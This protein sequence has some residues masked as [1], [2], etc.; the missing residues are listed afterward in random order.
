MTDRTL[1]IRGARVVDGTGNPWFYGDVVMAGE[2]I[3]A[4]LPA[5]QADAASVAGAAS[6]AGAASVTDA[7]AV[8][9]EASMAEAA[10]SVEVVEA[11]GLVVCPGFIDLQSH[12]IRPLMRDPRCLSKITQ[13]VTTE[14]M[15]EAWTPAPAGGRREEILDSDEPEMQ[16]WVEAARGWTRFGDW[17]EAMVARGVSPNVGSFLG[18]GTLREY[19]RG[20]DMG[21]ST[22]EE[23]ATMHRVVAEAM[24]DGAF[25]VSYALIYPPD[26]FTSTDELVAVCRE[27][28][29]YGGV[30]ITHIRDEAEHLLPALDEAIAIGRQ[31]DLPVEIY[32]LKA[33]GRANWPLMPAAIERIERAREQGIDVTAD[34]YPYAASGTGLSSVLPPWVSAGGRFYENLRDPEMRARIREEVLHPS[35]G[36]EPMGTRDGPEAVMPVGFKRAANRG[37]AGRRLS[38]IAEERGQNWVD[39]AIDLLLDEEQRIATIYFAMCEDNLVLQLRQPWIKIATDAGGVDPAWCAADGPIHPRAYGT[40]P[41]VLG[42]YVRE[43]KVLTLEDAIRKMTSAPADRI[44]LRDRGRLQA[45]CYADVVIFD[46]ATVGD[47]ATF[48]DSHRLSEGIRDVWVNGVSVLRN[49]DHTGATPG[50]VVRRVGAR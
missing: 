29:R 13:G 37:Y 36:W 22:P 33:A 31:A 44:G 14:I 35:G 42:R 20:L 49:G 16:G 40:Y 1:L 5:G 21:E 24:E 27:V 41:R 3:E 48:E 28:A 17:L 9:G 25:G 10:G 50:Q 12:S 46:P 30:Y 11:A 6:M 45:G 38:Q 7:A 26:S 23:M 4:V 43:E 18:G 34:M 47:R 2:R 39:T 15:G 19:A 32:H 8:P